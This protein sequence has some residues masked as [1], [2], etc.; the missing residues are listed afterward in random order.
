ME[1]IKEANLTFSQIYD[2]NNFRKLGHLMVELLADQLENVQT[3]MSHVVYPHRNPE[4]QLAFWKD[5]LDIKANPFD[6]FKDIL[7]NS[8]QLQ[9][10][11]FMGHQT[12]SP[13]PINAFAGLLADFLNNGTGVYEMGP[14]SNAMERTV[15]DFTA[16]HIGYS[17]EASGFITSGGSLANLTALLA[18]RK[19][20][21]PSD[22][23]E[24]GH[25]HKLAIMVSEEAHYCVDRSARIMGL[26]DD[27]IVKVPVDSEFKL[28]TDLLPK[29]L[30]EAKKKGLHVFCVIGCGGSTAT[31]SYD[32]LEA[33][34][35]FCKDNNLWLHVDAAHGGGVVFSKKYKHL[36][37]GIEKADTVVIDYH[38][39][40]MTPALNTALLFK[41]SS[42]SYETFAQ[43]AQYLWDTPE[44]EEWYNSAKRTFE[45]TKSLL[46]ARVYIVLKTYG[47]DIFEK[48]I[49]HLYS[50]ASNLAELV[51]DHP[52]FELAIQPESNIVNFRYLP[53]T[54]L[55]LEK[56]N[57]LNSYLRK[58]L[59]ESG[60]FY[61]VQTMIKG[62]RYLRCSI[63]NPLTT[64]Q[65]FSAMLAE[66][67]KIASKYLIE[68][69][70]V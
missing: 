47:T 46:S 13:P 63:M 12:A 29:Y 67:E 43:R 10:P 57:D 33:I 16:K 34:A 61:I 54:A 36:V 70:I 11:R 3:D 49:D 30:D 42:K 38:K 8:T 15:I 32:D 4:E 20:K 25:N 59:I 58:E 50:S 1:S 62:V 45:C 19:A 44:T 14:A 7:Q 27:G 22:V 69:N 18:A 56:T 31:G 60:K 39:M 64:N 26:G 35:D 2:P 6:T 21:A 68:K 40:L 65:D 51:E 24:E 53:S 23:W 5:G 55:S 41:N 9:H 48:N 52:N 37:K 66:I 28:R 17:E